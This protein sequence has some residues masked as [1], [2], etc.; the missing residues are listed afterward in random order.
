MPCSIG[1]PPLR[2]RTPKTVSVAMPF[3]IQTLPKLLLLE[4]PHLRAESSRRRLPEVMPEMLL[5]LLR[6][7]TGAG[8]SCNQT[9][10]CRSFHFSVGHPQGQ[11][12]NSR[13][14]P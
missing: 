1:G 2:G 3:V 9:R 7:T 4:I 13:R 6:V 14:D 12:G 11:Q 5:A 8:G 10:S